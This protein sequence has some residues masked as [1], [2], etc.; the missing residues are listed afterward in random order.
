MIKDLIILLAFIFSYC[1]L[2]F[3]H[4]ST[5]PSAASHPRLIANEIMAAIRWNR[6]HPPLSVFVALPVNQIT[7]SILIF[8]TVYASSL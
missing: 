2:S 6:M 4:I 1:L 8:Y 5:F 3:R 7:A